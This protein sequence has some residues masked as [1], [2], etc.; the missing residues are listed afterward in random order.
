M[1]PRVIKRET[2]AYLELTLAMF[3]DRVELRLDKGLCIKCDICVKV[4]PRE[5]ITIIPAEAGLDITIDPRLC[6]MCEICAHFCPVAAVTLTYNREIKT[7]LADHQGLAPFL[8]KI[9]M[10]KSRCLL[11]CPVAPEGEE[12]WC[13]QQLQLVANDLT[14]CPKQCFKCLEVCARHAIVLDEAARETRPDPDRCLR[15]THCLTV[16]EYEAIE[17]NPQFQGRL[18]ID[19]SKCPPDCMKCIDLCP[20]RAIVREGEQVFLGMETC[21]YC[22]VCVNACDEEAITLVR[23]EVVAGAGD[24]SRAWE[25][26]VAKLLNQE[27]AMDRPPIGISPS[28]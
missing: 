1:H 20:V 14:E 4:C 23:E 13:R 6:L 21:A 26:A 22:G 15:C 17:V 5:A 25:Q 8:P 3:V 19:D 10:D 9:A 18:V 28:E 2:A 11:P 24:F 16:C 12:H 7:I 27:L